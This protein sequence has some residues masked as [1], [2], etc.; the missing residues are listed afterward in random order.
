MN[1]DETKGRMIEEVARL[2]DKYPEA[3]RLI[4]PTI[5]E[6]LEYRL[7]EVH[8]PLVFIGFRRNE[9]ADQGGL[10]LPT[11]LIA[12]EDVWMIESDYV[13]GREVV[14]KKNLIG[15]KSRFCYP[16]ERFHDRANGYLETIEGIRMFDRE[17]WEQYRIWKTKLPVTFNPSVYVDGQRDGKGK[18]YQRFQE[19]FEM[20]PKLNPSYALHFNTD[21][22]KNKSTRYCVREDCILYGPYE[23]QFPPYPIIFQGDLVLIDTLRQTYPKGTICKP[24][25]LN[26]TNY[27]YYADDPH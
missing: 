17:T 9:E 24:G 1:V 13:G 15:L 20:V 18:L 2:W 16:L 27:F 11:G 14:L 10:R 3:P 4:T 21:M 7:K 12:H 6:R 5:F 19:L 26:M 23:T 8:C 22:Y 25:A